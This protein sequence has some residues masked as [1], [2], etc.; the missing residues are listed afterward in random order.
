MASILKKNNTR[1]NLLIDRLSF[2]TANS[3]NFGFIEITLSMLSPGDSTTLLDTEYNNFII[4]LSGSVNTDGY[5]IVPDDPGAIWIFYNSLELVPLY[6]KTS[7]QSAAT[8]AL[9]LPNSSSLCF[10]SLDGTDYNVNKL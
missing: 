6:I 3:P 7:L 2:N 10:V 9:I 4:K 8:A 5:I 1:E